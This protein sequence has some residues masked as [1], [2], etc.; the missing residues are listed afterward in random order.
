MIR[1][2]A[3]AAL[4]TFAGL[5]C[6]FILNAAI[7][8]SPSNG[9]VESWIQ[10]GIDLHRLDELDSMNVFGKGEY[11]SEYELVLSEAKHIAH[12]S[13]FPGTNEAYVEYSNE[14]FRDLRWPPVFWLMLA[15]A[16]IVSVAA[17][18]WVHGVTVAI[19]LLTQEA[20]EQNAEPEL[21]ITAS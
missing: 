1:V 21:P 2:V 6:L 5:L 3:I 9:P 8:P 11:E 14:R 20:A 7:Q 4:L 18:S 19:S 10:A 12:H 17:F 15:T 13:E 16:L